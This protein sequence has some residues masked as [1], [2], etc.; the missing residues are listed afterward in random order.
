MNTELNLPVPP[1]V[2]E[3]EEIEKDPEEI[4]IGPGG[5]RKL[6]ARGSKCK[7]FREDENPK[8]V[9]IVVFFVLSCLCFEL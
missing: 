9:G 6:P 1:V 2:D 3:T 7:T 8:D 4:N 5:Y